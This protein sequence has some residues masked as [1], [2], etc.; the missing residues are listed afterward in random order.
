MLAIEMG[1]T[2]LESVCRQGLCC[3]CGNG[4]RGSNI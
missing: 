3:G 1:M 2:A 4:A